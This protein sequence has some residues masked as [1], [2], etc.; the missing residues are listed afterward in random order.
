MGLIKEL[1]F[2]MLLD[3]AT[4]E[5]VV[6]PITSSIAGHSIFYAKRKHFRRKGMLTESEFYSTI[7][8]DEL[9]I[10]DDLMVDASII[11]DFNKT[12]FNINKKDD[13]NVCIVTTKKN[14]SKIKYKV[15]YNNL[16]KGKNKKTELGTITKGNLSK[17]SASIIVHGE[18]FIE[19]L[20]NKDN[21]EKH[22]KCSNPDWEIICLSNCFQYVIF[23]NKIKVATITCL[24]TD[25]DS[26]YFT[27]KHI[28]QIHNEDDEIECLLIFI[29]VTILDNATIF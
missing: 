12:S 23:H 3:V 16:V 26:K 2:D 11:H 22:F 4:D 20:I 5:D 21:G 15:N 6:L 28:M 29:T 18:Q 10:I 24:M 13:T 9:L 14:L 27:Y 8:S 1:L 17:N 25:F 7:D 19:L